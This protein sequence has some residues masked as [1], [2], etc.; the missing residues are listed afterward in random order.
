VYQYHTE[1]NDGMVQMDF[2]VAVCETCDKILLYY[3]SSQ[4]DYIGIDY[5]DFQTASL[6]WPNEGT[7]PKDIPESVRRCYY[8]AVRVK[9]TSP[10]AFALL[11]RRALEALCDDRKAVGGSLEK[12]LKDLASKDEIPSALTETV[13]VL[14]RLGN[15]SAHTFDLRLSEN[16]AFVM[17]DL[18]R[19]IIEYVYIGPSKLR[20]LRAT[21]QKAERHE[22]SRENAG[23]G[24]PGAENRKPT[25]H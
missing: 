7:L 13:D 2:F 17:D 18:F 16:D 10:T 3:I 5:E 23:A 6:I 22:G 12:R 4:D 11:I 8:E 9:K 1:E 19:A 20:Q 21:L 24:P 15:V 25:V 14:R